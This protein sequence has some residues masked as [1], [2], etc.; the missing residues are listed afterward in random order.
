MVRWA[1][2]KAA[3]PELEGVCERAVQRAVDPISLR[4]LRLHPDEVGALVYYGKRVEPALYHRRTVADEDGL[5]TVPDGLSPL[6]RKLVNG[7]KPLPSLG[8]LREFLRFVDWHEAGT[9]NVSEVATALAAVLPAEADS[10]EHFI[11]DHIDVGQDGDIFRDELHDQMLPYCGP[12]LSEVLEAAAVME[13]PELCRGDGVEELGAWYDFWD[14]SHSSGDIEMGDF[15]FAVAWTMYQALGDGIDPE[16]KEAAVRLFVAELQ[17]HGEG[18]VTRQDFLDLIAPALQANLPERRGVPRCAS[19]SS[20]AE[21]GGACKAAEAL[22]PPRRPLSLLLHAPVSGAT[23]PLEASASCTIA[24]LGQAASDAWAAHG[25]PS[26]PAPLFYL[27]GKALHEQED[28]TSLARSS[29]G[30]RDGAVIQALPSGQSASS[31]CTM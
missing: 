24:E 29:R 7:F 26:I 23:A 1:Q 3:L 28:Q 21:D 15:R 30:F 14:S 5:L 22:L 8:E 10:V 16:T 11:R 6:S 27:A 19:A 17:L 25:D 12:R 20:L 13:V 2:A 31:C 18:R 9:L 4:E